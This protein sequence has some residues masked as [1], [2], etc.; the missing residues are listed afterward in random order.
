MP[1]TFTHDSKVIVCKNCGSR[2]VDNYC[3]ICGQ[4]THLKRFTFRG[5][6]SVI[7]SAFSLEKGFIL[8]AKTLTINPGKLIHE[9]LNGRTKDYYNPL[10]YLLIVSAINALLFLKF[11]FLD[12]TIAMTNDLMGLDQQNIELQAKLTSLFIKYLNLM[13]MF[14]FPFISIVSI[15]FYRKHKLNYVEHLIINCYVYS[16]VA[17]ISIFIFP[18]YLIFPILVKYIYLIAFFVVAVYITYAYHKIFGSSIIKSLL[19]AVI[20]NYLGQAL[21]TVVLMLLFIVVIVVLAVLGFD[22]KSFLTG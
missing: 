3:S 19:G 20:V 7:F 22:V 15:L 21:F 16:H 10:K 11:K 13:M 1:F 14:M 12:S 9:Y 17:L 5:F 8:T 4:K 6:L 18:F 2:Q